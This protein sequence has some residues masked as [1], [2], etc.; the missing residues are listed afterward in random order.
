M[1]NTAWPSCWQL[2]TCRTVDAGSLQGK[3]AFEEISFG[4]EGF[5][6]VLNNINLKIRAGET[7]AFVSPSGAGKT[8]LCSLL[9]RFY[10]VTHGN[11]RIDE[12]NITDIT[13]SCLRSNIGIVQ[14]DVYLF[15]GSIRENITY[16]EIWEAHRA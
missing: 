12:M 8:T 1:A 14:Q 4:Y 6:P 9:P 10:E 2:K 16:D 11:I 3:I 7:V 15:S 13:L 5:A